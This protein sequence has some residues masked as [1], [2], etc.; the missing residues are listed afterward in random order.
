MEGALAGMIEELQDLPP[1]PQNRAALVGLTGG[2]GA[3]KS[4]VANL[5]QAI[6]V[7]IIDADKLSR[8]VI[9]PNTLGWEQVIGVFGKGILDDRGHVNRPKMAEIVFN[10]REKLERLEKIVHPLVRQQVRGIAA[11]AP[12]GQVVVY[13]VTLLAEKKLYREVDL[14]IGVGCS[15]EERLERLEKRGMGK[16]EATL[17]MQAQ[18]SDERRREVCHLWIDNSGD[19]ES[20]QRSVEQLWEEYLRPEAEGWK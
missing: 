2:I 20:L 4:Q 14:A 8:E 6:P 5:L 12:A 1:R 10:D 3:G 18:T 17:R 13:E 11:L 16:L 9:E 7:E 15:V 19:Y